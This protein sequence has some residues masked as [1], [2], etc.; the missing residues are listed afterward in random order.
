MAKKTTS[1]KTAGKKTISKRKPPAAPA[2]VDERLMPPP[3]GAT[4]RM[5]RIGHGDCFLIAFA[6][7]VPGRPAYVLIDCGYKPGSPGKIHPPAGVTTA[8]EIAT[9]IKKATGGRIDVA[10]ITHEHQDHVN[11]ITD[12]HF[13]GIDIGEAW[14]AWTENPLDDLA[15]DLRKKF[16][17]K[18]LGL[19]A[20]RN[21]LA[22][23]PGENQRVQMIDE[24]LA[25]ELGGEDEQMNVPAAMALLGAAAGESMNKRSMKVFKDKAKNGIKFLL[26]HERI[27]R[28]PH[29]RQVRVFPLGPPRDADLLES[30]DPAGSEEFHLGA[31]SSGSHFA[32]AARAVEANERPEAPFAQRYAVAWDRAFDGNEHAEFFAGLYGQG[33]AGPDPWDST[34]AVSNAEWR[35]IDKDWLYA[36][37]Q[38]ALDMND[39]TNNSSLVLAFELGKDGKVLLFAADAQRGNWIS[40]G[41]KS[42]KDGD[43]TITARDLLS[44]TVLYKVGHHGSHNAT[45]NGLATDEYANLAWMAQGDSA[46]EFCAMITAVRA[47][48]ETQKGWDHPLKAIKD[49]LLKKAGGRV[50]QTDT[51]FDQMKK[52]DGGSAVEWDSFT[53]RT[54]GTRLYFDYRIEP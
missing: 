16:K 7:D 34:E 36:A 44:R 28:L 20:A 38:L 18:L 21:R 5:Y 25:F 14:F 52:S 50:F 32:A 47:W 6:G 31:S 24:L 40:W 1:K 15:N 54:I 45:I 39:Q 26:P 9:D 2:A 30:L 22:A 13:D 46:R 29:A 12:T 53:K 27:Y 4:V 48:A 8:R 17:D 19:V 35:R 42:F 37:D 11:G 49:A 43:A 51:D 33:A 41:R 23:A 10:V 3:G